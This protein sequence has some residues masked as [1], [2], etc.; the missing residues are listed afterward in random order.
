MSTR[1][2]SVIV[3]ASGGIGRAFVRRRVEQGAEVVACAR[4][5]PVDLPGN[6]RLVF[7]DIED[8][9]TV[10][11]ASLEVGEGVNEVI[12]ASGML[13]EE[14]RGV[15]PEKALRQLDFAKLA[16]TF[17]V[18]AIGPMIV[19]KYFIPLFD[20][21]SRGLFAALSARV[22]SIEDNRMGGWYGYR[23][24]KAALNQFLKT[25]SIELKRT[26]P[27]LIVAGLHPGTVDTSLSKPFQRGVPETKLFAPEYS[28]ERL[29][30]V[31]SSLTTDDSGG[32]F[33]WA[34]ERVPA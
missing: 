19:A 21:E 31:L 1:Q 3:G 20:A 15:R 12:V 7:V 9:S 22:G 11:A 28:S 16:T 18:N 5:E 14:A 33:D 27:E 26:H 30:E 24:S 4:T 8:E 13:H 29:D 25:A 32:V 23:A 2:K 17:A 6:V 34:G 10:K